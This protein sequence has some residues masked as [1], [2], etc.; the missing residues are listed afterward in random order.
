MR[1]SQEQRDLQKKIFIEGNSEKIKEVTLLSKT[2]FNTFI[3]R[4]PECKNKE[5]FSQLVTSNR[6][7]EAAQFLR[8]MVLPSGQSFSIAR[9]CLIDGMS[10][11]N[12]CQSDEWM[13]I[14][15]ADRERYLAFAEREFNSA[16]LVF[17]DPESVITKNKDDAKQ[18]ARKP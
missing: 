11:L 3:E 6:M 10:F 18:A 12:D 17:D 4:L 13:Y 15:S 8:T 9:W 16:T 2:A 1:L 5:I 7:R 14:D